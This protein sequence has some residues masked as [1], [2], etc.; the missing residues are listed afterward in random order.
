MVFTLLVPGLV[1]FYVPYALNGAIPIADG[2]WSAG[3]LATLAGALIYFRC[4]IAFLASPGTPAMFFTRPLRALL[5]EEPR[6]LV[7]SALYGYSRNPMYIGVVMMVAGEAVAAHSGRLAIY[8]AALCVAFHLVV[9]LVEEPHLRRR[10]GAEYE[11]YTRAVPRWF[12]W[13]KPLGGKVE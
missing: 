6:Q 8:A 12:S 10:D 2:P 3:W 13:K 1:A 11:Q 9:I 5:G 4:L 7:R